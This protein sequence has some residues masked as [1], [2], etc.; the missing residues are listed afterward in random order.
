M[1]GQTSKGMRL[2]RINDATPSH[3]ASSDA[4]ES[5]PR[6][7]E[8]MSRWAPDARDRLEEAALELFLENGY[9]QTTV[10]QIA[11]RAGLNRATFFRHFSDKREVLFGG[12]ERLSGLLA[13]GVR[14]TP[15]GSPVTVRLSAAL[16][17]LGTVI[18]PQ[19][20]GLSAQRV[21]VLQASPEARERGLAKRARMAAEVRDALGEL[22]LRDITARLGGDLCVLAFSI[23]ME[24]WLAVGN[25]QSFPDLAT[26]ALRDLLDQASVFDSAAPVG[27]P[28]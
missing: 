10:A 20:R 24:R 26:T 17:A 16:T 15:S 5:C 23:G 8:G 18:T 6:Y 2:S 27:E 1:I 4:T 7:D 12:E 28:V 13:D 21:R 19:Q 22:G 25:E 3:L 14:S 9:E 11:E